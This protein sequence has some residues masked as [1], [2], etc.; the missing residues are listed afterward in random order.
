MTQYH[1]K[2]NKM[3]KTMNLPTY[4]YALFNDGHRMTGASYGK[5]FPDRDS[6]RSW[7]AKANSSSNIDGHVYIQRVP[8]SKDWETFR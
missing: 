4:L 5:I 8:V 1:F 7:K 2:E 6:A 3:K